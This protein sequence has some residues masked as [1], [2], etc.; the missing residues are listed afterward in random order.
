MSYFDKW[1]DRETWGKTG[2][3]LVCLGLPSA[4]AMKRACPREACGP[5]RMTDPEQ[6]RNELR[7]LITALDQM[8]SR[9]AQARE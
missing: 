3:E 8:N 4:F 1:M 6:T 5:R 7:E 9:Q 2:K